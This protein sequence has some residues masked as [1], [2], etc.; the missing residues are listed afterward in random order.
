MWCD[1]VRS[2]LDAGLFIVSNMR[3]LFGNFATADFRQIWPW[4]VSRGWNADFG[5]KFMKS[6]L[7]G[8]ICPPNPKLGG[9]HS[10]QVTGQGMHWREILFTPRCSSR[11]L[12]N[13][14]VRRTAA[15]S[16][17][18]NFRILAYFPHTKRQKSTFR[19]SA[20]SRGVTSQNDYDFSVWQSKVQRGAFRQRNFL[21]TFGKRAGDPQTCP[22]FRLCGLLDMQNVLA[23]DT[24]TFPLGGV[25]GRRVPYIN[26]GPLISPK[27]PELERLI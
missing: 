2:V 12:D 23:L 4:H 11:S 22:N 25:Q 1:G 5:H 27:L 26:L 16:Q 24:K 10:E 19:W 14:F 6:F 17:L 8:V 3:W 15:T 7:S 20:Y 9:G 13:F 21:A 18:P